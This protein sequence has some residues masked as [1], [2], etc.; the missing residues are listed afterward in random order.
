M[1]KQTGCAGDFE[2]SPLMG[3]VII[4]HLSALGTLP[5]EG[6]LAGQAVS[7]ALF[8][9]FVPDSEGLSVYND[10]DV[11]Y[12][13]TPDD[14]KIVERG[15]RT[16]DTVRY[17]DVEVHEHYGHMNLRVSRAYDII[18]SYR[19]GLVNL[20]AYD[21]LSYGM[22]SS[23]QFGPQYSQL[24][25]LLQGFDLNCTQVGISLET[26]RMEW[27]PAFEEFVRTRQLLIANIQTPHH[28]AMRWF[29]K[30]LDL[31]GA[32]GR[33]QDAMELVSLLSHVKGAD[34]HGG[35]LRELEHVR[36]RFG[37]KNAELYSRFRDQ[38]APYFDLV[39]EEPL[40]EESTRTRNRRKPAPAFYYLGA[41]QQ[42]DEDMIERIRPWP[43]RSIASVFNEMRAP[44]KQ[45]RRARL[46]S[47]LGRGPEQGDRSLSLSLASY[48]RQGFVYLDGSVDM[49]R[50][51][52]VDEFAV[53][54]RPFVPYFLMLGA[55]EQIA[56]RAAWVALERQH[57]EWIYG[58]VEARL[59]GPYGGYRNEDLSAEAWADDL[60]RYLIETGDQDAVLVNRP[61]FEAV[62]GEYSVRELVTPRELHEE[63]DALHH[64]VGGYALA[65]RNKLSRILQIRHPEKHRWSTLEVVPAHYGEKLWINVQHMSFGNQP[66]HPDTAALVHGILD[67]I[68]AAGWAEHYGQMAE[69]EAQAMP[70]TD[71]PGVQREAPLVVE[72]EGLD[73]KAE[74][75]L[76]TFDAAVEPAPPRWARG[77]ITRIVSWI[78]ERFSGRA[79]R[80]VATALER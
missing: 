5:Q 78:A 41:R 67:D 69:E 37:E 35:R 1:P 13:A 49:P 16:L 74:T 42:P 53:R 22:S 77:W 51:K 76:H 55:N 71:A 19:D 70:A 66:V 6:F 57:G 29:K 64:C 61:R 32:F 68:D 72:E 26:K 9:L 21:N 36:W 3:E 43:T 18:R 54:H 17:H 58:Y 11:F 48:L 38:L 34:G 10:L 40:H 56:Q 62:Y 59:R 30:R 23:A 75:D 33:D 25:S 52:G 47:V 31:P 65:V 44:R 50:L 2:L 20:V 28:T 8:D 14:E 7:S 80:S 79:A 12:Q 60:A 45:A 24:F 4:D 15:R 27:T 46:L 39:R 73:S 63:G